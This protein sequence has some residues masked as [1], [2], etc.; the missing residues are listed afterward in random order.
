MI[1]L[2]VNFWKKFFTLFGLMSF[3]SHRV[4]LPILPNLFCS[5]LSYLW[6]HFSIRTINSFSTNYFHSWIKAMEEVLSEFVRGEIFRTLQASAPNLSFDSEKVFFTQ[7]PQDSSIGGTVWHDP[8][9]VLVRIDPQ[10]QILYWE[11]EVI[12]ISHNFFLN[13]CLVRTSSIFIFGRDYRCQSGP[14][15]RK[16]DCGG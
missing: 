2:I 6:I 4:C 16:F 8:L 3:L 10:G 14:G 13:L 7:S 15:W 1:H 11:G 12:F 5:F 9:P